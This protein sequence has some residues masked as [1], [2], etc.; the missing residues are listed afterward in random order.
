MLVWA[1]AVGP[2]GLAAEGLVA[3]YRFASV[4]DSGTD[5]SSGKGNT[6]Q[7]QGTLPIRAGIGSGL[8][9]DGVD[10]HVDCGA[11]ESLNL[12]KA[13]SIACWVRPDTIPA[14]EVGIAGK[15]TE[16]YGL[17]YY[18]DGRCWWYISGGGNSVKTGLGVGSWSHVVGTYDGQTSRLY[19]NGELRDS[20]PITGA[21]APGGHFLIG[22]LGPGTGAF[23]GAIAAVRVFD[24]ALAAETI[25]AEYQTMAKKTF[26]CPERIAG[27]K[28]LGGS[29]YTVRVSDQG[30]IEIDIGPDRYHL[31]TRLSYPAQSMGWN[32]LGTPDPTGEKP[33]APRISGGAPGAVEVAANGAR[34]SVHRTI[35]IEGHRVLVTDAVTNT[36]QEDLGILYR[37]ELS[38]PEPL[39]HVRLAG[40]DQSGVHLTAPN[41]STFAGQPQSGLAWLAED[42]VLRLQLELAAGPNHVRMSADRFALLPG[43]SHT[44]R[45]ALYPL[46]AEADYWTF[47]NQVRRDWDV[48]FTVQG[49]FDYFDL[50]ERMD[51]IR[52]PERLKAYLTRKKLNVIAFSPWVDYEN[53]NY[54]TGRPT[55]RE[56]LKALLQEAMAAVRRVAPRIFCIGC[57]E[58]NLVSLPAEAQQAL[59][60]SAPNRPQGQYPLTEEQMAILRKCDIRWKDCLLHNR[61]GHCRYELY[62][63]GPK[64]E[65]PMI[66]I[67]VY[68][69]PGNGQHL[70]WL[71]QAKFLL[72]EVGLDGL[73]IDQF[74][75]AFNDEQRYSYDTWDGTTVDIDQQTGQIV[76]RYTD[77][78]LVGIG[79]RRD[80][81]DYV[82]RTGKYMLANTFPA[83]PEMQSV[84]MHRFNESEWAVDVFAW[85][86]GQEPPL[87][88][89][90]CEGHF[91]T[92]ISLGTRPERY[93]AKGFENYANV[94]MKA[95]VAYLRHGLLYYH[96]VT[97]IPESG[98]GAG[99][100]GA[101]NHMFPITPVELHEGWI[102]GKE[103]TV[104]CVSGT[105]SWFE[106]REPAVL[107]F[108]LTGHPVTSRAAVTKKGDSWQVDLTLKDWAEIAIIE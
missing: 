4:A 42:A 86:D 3:E 66:A 105:Y 72:E 94:I 30:G 81:A 88:A 73:Y 80:L 62:Y 14:G 89:Y 92:P 47:V 9:F 106:T 76:R 43:K 22:A 11:G 97:E 13:V 1:L 107:V 21:I 28:T 57:I 90:P 10:D 99:E 40:A 17:T 35:R 96:Y 49:P 63:R 91:S 25:S 20:R 29:G 33:W 32:A 95:A 58:G 19:V 101:I 108:D 55:T 61:N 84:R 79:A 23:K 69:A 54:L 93:G 37:H 16:S 74:N 45:W 75:M 34:Y 24:R 64:K 77:A 6:A 65:T 104:I 103:R 41:P 39:E 46:P 50:T 12:G 59:W 8:L 52:D 56:E 71:D 51:L 68:A 53:Y 60:D 78:G 2:A 67:A 70:Y 31:E 87:V 82:L 38:T 85:A 5:D 83:V 100:Y 15:G 18:K 44:F 27:G 48:N 36:S 102:V 98:T 26:A 7:I